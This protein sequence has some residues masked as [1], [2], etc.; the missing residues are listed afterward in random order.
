MEFAILAVLVVS[1]I[2]NLI[3]LR[4]LKSLQLSY[5]AVEIFPLIDSASTCSCGE[6]LLER[7]EKIFTR[8][9]KPVPTPPDESHYAWK[10]VKEEPVKAPPSPHG[11]PPIPGP[12]ARPY[13]FPL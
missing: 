1:V 4:G 6:E 7:V 11:P 5:E 2:T 8:A 3:T 13:G 9:E 12:L 10:N